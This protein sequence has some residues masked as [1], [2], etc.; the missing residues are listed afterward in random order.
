MKNLLYKELKLAV[1]PSIFIFPFIGMLLLIPA[2]P[3]F[4]AF[5]YTFIGFGN[6][7]MMGKTNQDVFFTVSLPIRKKD[8]VAARFYT[9]AAIE[10]LQIAVAIPFA[11]ISS[12]INTQ[13]NAAGIDA[14]LALFGFVFIMYAIFNAVFLPLFY[15]T[16]YKIAMPLFLAIVSVSVFLVGAEIAVQMVPF[17]KNTLDTPQAGGMIPQL[18]ILTA[19]I[20]IFVLANILACKKAASNF[21]K[22]DL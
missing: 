4:V 11:I 3:Y 18:L 14:N 17:L 5:V 7:F 22:V 12:H 21:E 9:I 15:K 2:Y 19:G 20:L 16:G 1:H 8:V 10:L 6:L 13:G